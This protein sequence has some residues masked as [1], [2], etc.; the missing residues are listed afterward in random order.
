MTIF[1]NK[2][3]FTYFKMT[4]NTYNGWANRE[5]WNVALWIQNDENLYNNARKC[6]SYNEFLEVMC[7][8]DSATPD[9]VSYTD[10]TLDIDELNEMFVEL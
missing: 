7:F 4:D 6:D 5:T 2:L 3:F 9:G 8:S 10:S 1:V